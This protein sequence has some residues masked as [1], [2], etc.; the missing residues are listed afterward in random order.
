MRHRTVLWDCARVKSINVGVM[1]AMES[2]V[3]AGAGIFITYYTP[4]LLDWLEK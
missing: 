4:M 2:G 3:R 1:E